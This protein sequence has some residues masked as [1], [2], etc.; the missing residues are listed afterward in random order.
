M[1]PD[2]CIQSFDGIVWQGVSDSPSDETKG[3]RLQPMR[4][5]ALISNGPRL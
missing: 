5:S 2:F 1:L 3:I 4:E